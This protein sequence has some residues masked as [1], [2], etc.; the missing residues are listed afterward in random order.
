[1]PMHL[2]LQCTLQPRKYNN[3]F[4]FGKYM[5]R[6][7]FLNQNVSFSNSMLHKEA[8]GNMG[9]TVKNTAKHSEQTYL[10][11]LACE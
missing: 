4:C 2:K 9:L 11:H 10:I 8:A 1:M 5:R 3:Y 6:R 7:L